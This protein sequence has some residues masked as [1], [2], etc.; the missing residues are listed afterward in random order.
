[1]SLITFC[2]LSN[3]RISIQKRDHNRIDSNTV[4]WPRSQ[5]LSNRISEPAQQKKEE[6]NE[7]NVIQTNCHWSLPHLNT[8]VRQ[9]KGSKMT[10]CVQ[11]AKRK[12]PKMELM[13]G[14]TLSAAIFSE[15]CFQEMW[16]S[17]Q[18][19]QIF[20]I[21]VYYISW[22]TYMWSRNSVSFWCFNIFEFMFGDARMFCWWIVYN[23][24][25]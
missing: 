6:M 24:K 7:Q 9:L 10:T 12:V 13:S 15:N 16:S 25:P 5:S 21:Y 4:H 3:N 17:V 20:R 11:T 18:K 23:V 1:M 19:K 8:L 14:C 22:A 2:A